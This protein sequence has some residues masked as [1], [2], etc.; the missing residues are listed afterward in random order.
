MSKEKEISELD[1]WGDWHTSKKSMISFSFGSFGIELVGNA[2]GSLYFFFY[3][4]EILV[5]GLLIIIANV[6]F[7]LWNAINDPL[8]G[9][10]TERPRKFW[11]KWGRRFPW[12]A[13]S[14]VPMY[15]CYFLL[16][17]PPIGAGPIGYFAWMCAF[18]VLADTFY[19]MF[20]VNWQAMFPEKYRSD[21]ARRKGNVYKLV[22]AI[23]SIIVGTLIPP[24]IYEYGNTGS[25]AVMGAVIFLIGSI[26]GV[27]VIYG[28]REDPARRAQQVKEGEAEG[29][30]FLEA[31]KEAF[32]QG[33][34]NKAFV[35]FILLYFGNKIWDLFVLGSANYYAKWI[36]GIPASDL[37]EI[38]IFI[39]LGIIAGVGI[40]TVISK[41]VGFYKTAVIGGLTESVCT[42]PL[43]FITNVTL[44]YPFFFI[45]GIGNGA[46]WTML[47][48][49]LSD[50]L[51]SLSIQMKKRSSGI[52][53][54]IYAFFGRL[55]II[56]FTVLVI[57]IHDMTGFD[58]AADAGKG[59]QTPL[60][61]FGILITMAVIPVLGTAIFTILFALV[62]DIKG[63]KKIWLHEQLREM[64]IGR[65]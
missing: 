24:E 59:M 39:I 33:L 55:A 64:D 6:I 54:G 8:M 62:F 35:G 19:S 50:A 17:A 40:F 15:L 5:P 57:L 38:Y 49:I 7:A 12:M 22:L 9:Y 11:G 30:N 29:Q 37:T 18:L 31:F 2:F 61:D 32:G 26:A 46:M 1:D 34:K 53:T 43:L 47:A 3:E 28:S 51:D 41:K 58:A 20:F 23:L 56:L 25:F 44:S 21:D 63:E 36:L 4:T 60:A 48:P 16:F 10:L 14:L 27:S 42:I 13:I 65:K 45:V 52:Y